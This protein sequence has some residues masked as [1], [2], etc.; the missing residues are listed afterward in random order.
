VNYLNEFQQ[1][2]LI[3]PILD[4]LKKITTGP[5]RFMEFCGGHTHALFKY[6]LID[7]LPSE[8]QMIHGPGCPVCVLP[9]HPIKNCIKLLEERNDIIL[10][11][12]ADMM[13]VPTDE[14]D[15][16]LKARARGCNVAAVYGADDTIELARKN[17]ESKIIFLAIGFETTIPA[18]ALVLRQAKREQLKNFFVYCNH[19]NTAKALESILNSNLE[20]D[21]LIGPGHVSLVTG[22]DFFRPYATHL[23]LVISGFSAYDLAES[24]YLLTEMVNQKEKGVK[25]QYKRAVTNNGNLHSQKALQECFDLRDKFEWRGLGTISQSAFKIKKD[26][27][28][29]DAEKN[30]SLDRYQSHDHPHCLCSE[31]LFGQKNPLDCKLFGKAC[32]PRS[33]LGPCMVSSEGACSAYYGRVQ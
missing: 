7:L 9:A 22:S 27:E 6:G 18:T 32:T 24:L 25:N 33:P 26:Y 10:A 3:L 16:L 12:Y 29:W 30:F 1:K 2:D 19:L 20:L 15:S 5:Y 17:P 21:G 28:Q 13:R 4:K 31:V 11:T 14:G 8:I 23:P